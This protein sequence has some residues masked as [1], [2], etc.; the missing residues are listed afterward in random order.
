MERRILH[1]DMDAF[2]ASVEQ[3]RDPALQGRP[4][5]V[6]GLPGQRGV[7]SAASYEA[8]RYGL[9]SAMPLV[10]A[11]RLCPHAVFLPGDFSAYRACS[12]R[13]MEMFRELTPL[14]EPRSLDEAYLDLTGC[15]PLW[16]P[17]PE[18]AA[19]L[20]KRIRR[21]LGIT[22]SVG[23]ASNKLVA[24]IASE[25]R[26][27]DGLV[28]V[29]AG[30]EASFLAGL[31][32]RA[33]PGVGLATAQALQNLGIGRVGELAQ[34]PLAVLRSRFDSLAPHLVRMARGQD[35][36]PV[37]GYGE[38][39][40]ISRSITFASDTYDFAFVR[41]VAGC[42]AER[43][44]ARLRERS[45]A[46]RTVHLQLRFSD[47]E[48]ITRSS[49]L[50]TTTD[51]DQ[52]VFDEVERLLSRSL[53]WKKVRL[54]GVGVSGLGPLAFQT[55]LLDQRD[56]GFKLDR[57][58]DAIRARYGFRSVL[59]GRNLASSPGRP[60]PGGVGEASHSP[61]QERLLPAVAEAIG[62]RGGK[63]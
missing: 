48:T 42:L 26:K 32:V 18:V 20:K 39:K 40:S 54:V 5:V 29:A 12:R 4:V 59:R 9:H 58:L 7:V 2:F 19:G 33:L 10:V 34:A 47:F 24:K 43:V 28:E 46:A 8:R 30:Q 55:S 35:D 60:V 50:R 13:L 45:R 61:S 63:V 41:A 44:G 3:A 21:E 49:T 57:C 62:Q 11:Y 53:S 17:P 36:S 56:A 16:G 27:P 31:P 14:V 23:I 51:S 22:A 15:E 6:G 38:A 1:V 25:F 52:V 37:E